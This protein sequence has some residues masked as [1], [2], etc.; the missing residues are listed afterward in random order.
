M[1]HR[2]R[3]LLPSQHQGSGQSFTT[4]PITVSGLCPSGLL[5]K[6]FDNNIFA[7]SAECSSG[8]YELKIG[9]FDGTNS[10]NS[11]RL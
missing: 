10:L 3:R 8:S 1:G 2:H 4:L 11:I 7:G 6:V 5:I 9:L